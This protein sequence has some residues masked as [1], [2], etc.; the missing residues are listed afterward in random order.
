MAC[1]GKNLLWN[2]KIRP[3]NPKEKGYL[4]DLQADVSIIVNLT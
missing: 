3:E 1:V 4:E 2:K